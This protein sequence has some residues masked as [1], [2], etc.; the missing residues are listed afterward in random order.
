MNK[1]TIIK[2]GMFT[3]CSFLVS[4]LVWLPILLTTLII[5]AYIGILLESIHFIS[6]NTLIL[7]LPKIS[8]I[9]S[10]IISVCIGVSSSKLLLKDE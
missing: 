4:V 1:N 9:V 8:K 5:L 7:Y 6:M 2:I 3:I 10:S